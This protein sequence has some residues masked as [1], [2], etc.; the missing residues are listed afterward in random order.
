MRRAADARA[1]LLPALAVTVV[2]SWPAT[3]AVAADPAS[4]GRA[5]AKSAR[6]AGEVMKALG[7][8]QRWD[9]LK[10]LRWTFGSSQ[11]DTVRSSRRHA[12]DK[13][14]GWHRVEGKTRTGGTFL[15]IHDLNTGE[16]MAWMD[17]NRIEGDSL[18]TLL[19]RAKSIWINDTYWMLMPYKLRDPGV[20]LAY[21]GEAEADGVRYDKLALSFENV[22]DTP[23]DRYWVWIEQKSRR[24]RRWDMVLQGS[25]PPPRSYTWEGWEEHDGLWFPTAHRQEQ[26]NVFTRDI[27]TVKEFRPGE[28]TGP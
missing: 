26:A 19:K 11:A 2:L 9:A 10:G 27:E 21:D 12:W 5:D 20:I 16:G 1:G 22:G 17:G 7:G 6:L 8:Q 15:F 3:P 23:G 4:M 13:H 28:F 24:V 18:R 25:Q 14:T